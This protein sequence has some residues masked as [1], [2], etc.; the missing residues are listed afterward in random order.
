MIDPDDIR[1]SFEQGELDDWV[2]PEFLALDPE[3]MIFIVANVACS[4]LA[5]RCEDEPESIYLFEKILNERLES[6]FV[7]GDYCNEVIEH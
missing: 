4:I 7:K 5:A 3:Q 2:T 1:D 6:I